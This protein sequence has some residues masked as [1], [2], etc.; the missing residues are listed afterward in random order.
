MTISPP[1]IALL[2][3]SADSRLLTDLTSHA[4]D[5]SEAAN[6]LKGAFSLGE[7][8]ELWEPLT[9]H[10][11]TAYIRPFI[12]SNVQARLDQMSEI[13]PVPLELLSVH[14]TIRKYRNTAVAHSQSELVMPLPL[15]ILN[16]EG[17]GRDVV[18]IT[19]THPMPLAFAEHFAALIAAMENIVDQAT[20]PVLER[21]RSW[22]RT[23]TPETI[24]SWRQP[25]V[26]FSEDADFSA[27]R[28]RKRDPH[29]MFYAHIEPLS[30]GEN[31]LEVG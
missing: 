28:R 11:V 23:E 26:A 30:E 21:L 5:L 13:P 19:L 31:S 18:G 8:S 29:F 14:D 7:G 2:P 3:D 17:Q 16:D 6:A 10:A 4:N 12:T 24:Q 15:A 22:L 20:E 27:T 1:R 9:S 25:K